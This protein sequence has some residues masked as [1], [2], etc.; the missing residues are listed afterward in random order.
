MWTDDGTLNDAQMGIRSAVQARRHNASE[1]AAWTAKSA[2]SGA[3][4]REKATQA[5][6]IELLCTCSGNQTF[7]QSNTTSGL[8]G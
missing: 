4:N 8:I 3:S 6:S 7:S 1:D 2:A 5:L